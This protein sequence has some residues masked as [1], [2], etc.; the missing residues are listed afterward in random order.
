MLGGMEGAI[1]RVEMQIR[2]GAGPASKQLRE[3]LAAAVSR[4]ALLPGDRVL[5]VRAMAERLGLAP[6]TV[7]KAYREL[8]DGGW[9]EGRGR[10]GTFVTASPPREPPEQERAL[11]VAADR[12]VRRAEQ[13][14]FDRDAAIEALRRWSPPA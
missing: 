12:Y 7:A 5:P 13:L 14:G 6:N 3:Q 9:L 10:A 11:A 1:A 2:E 8:E 4:G